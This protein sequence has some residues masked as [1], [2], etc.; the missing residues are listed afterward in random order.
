MPPIHTKS[1][2]KPS[3]WKQVVHSRWEA[4]RSLRSSFA[5]AMA[6]DKTR[7]VESLLKCACPPIKISPQTELVEASC[8]LGTITAISLGGSSLFELCR[9]CHLRLPWGLA[10]DKTRLVESLLKCACPPIKI[11]PQTELVEASCELGT[12]T[13][14][15]L[16]G[17]S[18]FEH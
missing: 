3:L 8:E 10:H 7:L 16:G 1:R 6:H 11:S 18:L 12:I 17:S 15:S 2:P 9:G 5:I 4:R 14:I 13:A